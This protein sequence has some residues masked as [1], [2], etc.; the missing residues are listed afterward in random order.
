MKT[1]HVTTDN[2]TGNEVLSWETSPI[3]S[4]IDSVLGQGLGRKSL[5][6]ADKILLAG[7]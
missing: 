7:F 6:Q 5:T 3:P 4:H 2:S 1:E